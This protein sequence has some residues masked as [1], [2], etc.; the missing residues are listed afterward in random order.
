MK[1][2]DEVYCHRSLRSSHFWGFSFEDTAIF[3]KLGLPFLTFLMEDPPLSNA[4]NR[5]SIR[6]S[7]SVLWRCKTRGDTHIIWSWK[8]SFFTQKLWSYFSR[9]FVFQ[10]LNFKILYL[11]EFC[12]PE[13]RKGLNR[14][15]IL[16][17]IRIWSLL[18]TSRVGPF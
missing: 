14:S 2:V 12:T 9:N 1:I 3:S 13:A 5:I 16:S 18:N 6:S 17:S 4:A 11:L 15:E 7:V 10:K 8:L